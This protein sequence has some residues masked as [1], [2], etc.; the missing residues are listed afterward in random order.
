MTKNFGNTFYIGNRNAL[1]KKTDANIPVVITAHG[2]LQRTADSTYPF[3]Q[4]SNF[5]YLTGISEPDLVLVLDGDDEFMMVPGRSGSREAFDGAVDFDEITKIS[6]IQTVISEEEGWQRLGTC[7]KKAGKAQTLPPPAS[8]IEPYGMYTNPARGRLAERLKTWHAGLE[9]IDIR[10]QLVS[11][12]AIKQPA[13]LEALQQ[14]IDTTITGIGT[15]MG[16]LD[17]YRYEFEIENDLTAQFRTVTADGHA[18]DP[19]VAG[20]KRA[21]TM[22][23][24]ANEG[25]LRRGDLLLMDVGAEVSHYAADLT[26]TVA[27]GEPSKRQQQVYQAVLAVQEFALGLLK[28]GTVLKDYEAAVEHFMGEKLMEIG[29]I[30]AIEHENVR[31]YYPTATS[32]FLGL[33][34]HDVGD[35]ARPLEAGMVLTCEPG[36]YIPEESIGIRIEDD[37]LITAEGNRVLSDKLPRSL[38]S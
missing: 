27:L 19:I 1:R 29:L 14:A 2:L 13:E 31:H 3:M 26:R 38:K 10:D 18:F 6:G 20:G 30:K 28:P 33:D 34:V 37:V 25:K 22:H 7:L 24:V 23:N 17:V 9:I 36:I 21:C 16:R 15:V 12:R 35:Y 4:D 5:W 11:L 32:H 8:Y